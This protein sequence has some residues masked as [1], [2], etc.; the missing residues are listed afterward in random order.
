MYS[1]L[2]ISSSALFKEVAAVRV[3]GNGHREFLNIKSLH[4][5]AAEIFKCYYLAFFYAACSQ[6]AC[7]ADSA[8]IY[9]VI[10]LYSVFY[11]FA[12]FA[13]AYHCTKSAVKKPWC[14]LIH[15]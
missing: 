13:L 14:K 10:A 1:D 11:S 8:E 9:C 2:T 4:R 3:N 12:A 6:S 7:A 15:S 5:L